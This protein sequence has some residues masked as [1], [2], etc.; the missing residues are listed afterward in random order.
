VALPEFVPDHFWQG[1]LHNQ[2]AIPLK[3]ALLSRANTV[4]IG[5][6]YHLK[7]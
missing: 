6:P 1:V 3:R 7:R 2:S 5:V 4:V